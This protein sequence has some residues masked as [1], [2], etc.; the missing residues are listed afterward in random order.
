MR[1]REPWTRLRRKAPCDPTM[2][3]NAGGARAF[4]RGWT[5]LASSAALATGG[6]CSP[7]AAHRRNPWA[8][9]RRARHGRAL[10]PPRHATAAA[11]HHRARR[12]RAH[13]RRDHSTASRFLDRHDYR[14]ACPVTTVPADACMVLI[15][16][17]VTH[18]SQVR[19]WPGRRAAG[20]RLR[21]SRPAERLFAAVLHRGRRPDGRGRGRLRRPERRSPTWPPTAPTA[22][23]PPACGDRLLLEGQP[24]RRRP[25]R[26]RR[27]R[28]HRMGRR[29]VAGHRHGVGASARSATSSWSRPTARPW[30]ISAPAVNTAVSLGANFVSNSYGGTESSSDNCFDASYYNHPGVADHRLRR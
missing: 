10:R 1:L 9:R 23:L 2:P 28:Q 4:T 13:H 8:R 12:R 24:E 16:T 30:P 18:R 7:R 14:R 27:S 3:A 15:R 20:R 25:A 6:L 17:N 26:C 19:A 22:G 29:G 11:H 5:V 21:A